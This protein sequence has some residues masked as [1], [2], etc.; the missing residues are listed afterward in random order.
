MPGG[1]HVRKFTDAITVVINYQLL[2]KLQ[3]RNI[4]FSH[5]EQTFDPTKVGIV[6][7]RKFSTT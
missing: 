2:K 6:V 1:F 3:I 5:K 4:S 7:Y